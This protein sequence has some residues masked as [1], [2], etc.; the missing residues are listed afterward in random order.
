MTDFTENAEFIPVLHQY[1]STLKSLS[2]HMLTSDEDV[3][4]IRLERNFEV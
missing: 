1:A 3:Y 4:L 2:S